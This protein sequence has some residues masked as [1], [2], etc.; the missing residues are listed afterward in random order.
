MTRVEKIGAA[1]LYLGDCREIAP[2]LERP[3]AVISDPPYGMKWDGKNLRGGKGG[4][5]PCLKSDNCGKP[6]IGDDAPFDPAPWLDYDR[7]ILWGLNHFPYGL[8]SGS[9]L[10]WVKR[11]EDAYGSFLSDAEI[12]WKK[13]GRGVYCFRDMS[14]YG[15]TLS[16]AH[17]T[18]KPVPL[19]KWC[20]GARSLHG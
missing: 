2:T 10:V 8:P 5:S 13:G 15:E 16:R 11:N 6:I 3:A 17:P 9:A 19:M 4:H 12:A 1:T 7:V 14:I 18:Q 20:I